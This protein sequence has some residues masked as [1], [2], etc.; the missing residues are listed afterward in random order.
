MAETIQQIPKTQTQ[1]K[2]PSTS[3]EGW[4]TTQLGMLHI[5]SIETHKFQ[6]VVLSQEKLIIVKEIFQDISKQ[7]LETSYTL[8]LGQLLKIAPKLKRYLWQKLKPKKIQNLGK[9]TI[10]KQISFSRLEVRIVIVA[11]NNHMAAIQVQI[12][13]NI[14]EDVLLDGG[15][16]VNIITKQL[17]LRLGLPKPKPAPYNLRMVD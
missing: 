10:N 17:K 11:I 12:K 9:A 15:C 14:V 1:T 3:M 7:M 8:N 5:T 6:K 2:G 13:Q 4:N 16:G